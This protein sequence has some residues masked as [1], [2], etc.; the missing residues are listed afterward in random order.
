MNGRQEKILSL[1]R[2]L[3]TLLGNWQELGE[4]LTQRAKTVLKGLEVDLS[5][6]YLCTGNRLVPQRYTEGWAIDVWL[7]MNSAEY[8]FKFQERY[9]D[10][11]SE[12]NTIPNIPQY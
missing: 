1:A 11:K 5:K 3:V 4:N 9:D 7:N 2:E 6:D 12:E 10:L 8:L